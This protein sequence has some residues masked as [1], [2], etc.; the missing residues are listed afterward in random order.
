MFFSWREL[1][2]V[3]QSL[4]ISD[5]LRNTAKSLCQYKLQWLSAWRWT[6]YLWVNIQRF[7]SIGV[8]LKSSSSCLWFDGTRVYWFVRQLSPLGTLSV[9]SLGNVRVTQFDVFIKWTIW[10]ATSIRNSLV[11][12]FLVQYLNLVYAGSMFFMILV[13]ELKRMQVTSCVRFGL[14]HLDSHFPLAV[15]TFCFSL[16]ISVIQNTRLYQL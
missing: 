9:S 13:R 12:W 1:C 3:L 7:R 15:I 10:S 8:G 14:V 16:F 6:P 11:L 5:Q 4:N 2:N